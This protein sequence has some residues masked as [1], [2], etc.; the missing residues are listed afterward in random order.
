MYC[1]SS[2]SLGDPLGGIDDVALAGIVG[3]FARLGKVDDVG[4]VAG[5]DGDGQAGFELF[6]ADVVD[7]DAGGLLKGRHRLGEA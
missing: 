3:R 6:V 2:Q 5:V 1:C 7:G 4:R